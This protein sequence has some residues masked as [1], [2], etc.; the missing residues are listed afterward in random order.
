MKKNIC[1]TLFL[2]F[3]FS[4]PIN[5]NAAMC[6]KKQASTRY[7]FCLKTNREE[8]FETNSDFPDD[9]SAYIMTETRYCKDEGYELQGNLCV[10]TANCTDEPVSDANN[11]NVELK[12]NSGVCNA[13]A[14]LKKNYRLELKVG[15]YSS[16]NGRINL[17]CRATVSIDSN[18]NFYFKD[19]QSGQPIK[20]LVSDSRKNQFAAG[21]GT[22][23]E[24]IYGSNLKYTVR[25]DSDIIRYNTTGWSTCRDCDTVCTPD[26]PSGGGGGGGGSKPIDPNDIEIPKTCSNTISSTN[27]N[28]SQ[29]GCTTSCS[30]YS[31]CKTTGSG[32]VDCREKMKITVEA[33][34][35]SSNDVKVK[36]VSAESPTSKG[37]VTQ[38]LGSLKDAGTTTDNN[39]KKASQSFNYNVPSA[40]IN[41][42]SGEILYKGINYNGQSTSTW[43]EVTPGYYI[44]INALPEQNSTINSEIG[45]GAYVIKVN[46]NEYK[47]I[48]V[49][50]KL[51]C[52]FKSKISGCPYQ[53]CGDVN[54]D[55]SKDEYKCCRNTKY[56]QSHPDYYNKSCSNVEEYI[57]RQ[58]SLTDP[59][60]SRSAGYNWKEWINQ[61]NNKKELASSFER[62]PDYT[63]ELTNSMITRIKEYNDKE[64]NA[65]TLW[66]EMNDDGSSNFLKDGTGNSIS[67]GNN[68]TINSTYYSLGCGPSNIEEYGWCK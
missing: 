5:I 33:I 25:Y 22:T 46:G 54:C 38:D 68:L 32:S 49:T 19:Y 45:G 12:T 61:E 39:N 27:T 50:G 34:E 26:P 31:C 66:N 11:I 16:C 37:K 18:Y 63:F 58:I 1:Y 42:K 29:V 62:E 3:L 2:A 60:P 21:T 24:V 44:P 14:S 36:Y 56:L 8:C 13:N 4:L 57:Y 53:D 55:P 47:K 20:S 15:E 9:L 65:Y 64:S 41:I 43:K 30:S 28:A 51:A 10:Q 6:E 40:F 17:V 48:S 23:F 67:I 52:D 7:K 35:A 59:F